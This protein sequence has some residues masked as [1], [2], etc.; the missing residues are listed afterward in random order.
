MTFFEKRCFICRRSRGNGLLTIFASAGKCVG[1][2][3]CASCLTRGGLRI[4][5]GDF[6]HCCFSIIGHLTKNAKI[7]FGSCVME[8]L[9][10]PKRILERA[11]FRKNLIMTVRKPKFVHSR[12]NVNIVDYD[13]NNG[14]I[15]KNIDI[16]HVLQRVSGHSSSGHAQSR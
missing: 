7:S 4:S 12:E 11:S 9:K 10:A 14:C 2:S 13:E 5:V 1:F 16:S 15:R 8:H 6:Q 3:K